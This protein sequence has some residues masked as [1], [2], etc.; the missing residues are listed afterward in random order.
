MNMIRNSRQNR[1]MRIAVIAPPW[2]PV[3]PIDYGGTELIID[4]LCRSYKEAGHDVV[5]YCSGDSTVGVD[6]RWVIEKGSMP[7]T[8]HQEHLHFA[9]VLDQ[10]QNEHFDI[11][12]SHLEG[13]IPY[14]R[15]FPA[16]LVTTLHVPVTDERKPVLND[17]NTTLAAI[18]KDQA[19]TIPC[20]STVIYNGIEF[21]RYS[22]SSNHDDYLL[23]L[24]AVKPEK[25]IE[26]AV[27][28]AKKTNRSLTIAGYL[29]EQYRQWFE[30]IL[31]NNGCSINFVGPANFD[32][33]CNL[34]QRCFAL[35]M[36]V[37]WREP[38]GLVALE[39]MACGRPVIASRQGALPEVID[40]GVSGFCCDSIEEYCDAVGRARI[41]DPKRIRDSVVMKFSAEKMVEGYLAL[42]AELLIRKKG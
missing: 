18:S 33:K 30:V 12:H 25:G 24:G 26:L 23:W 11:I 40:Q 10:L 32:T 42:F 19:A 41:M 28:I 29:A 9:F 1:A 36:P 20:N 38:F 8:K 21:D 37:N 3:P 22:A 7:P 16:P 34:L 15:L 6:C 13:F 4:I 39:A 14:S 35:L 5:L 17:A 2:L 31:N 27:E